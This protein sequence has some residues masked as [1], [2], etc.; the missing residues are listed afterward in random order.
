MA[1]NQSF[2]GWSM[3]APPFVMRKLGEIPATVAA[4]TASLSIPIVSGAGGMFLLIIWVLR[5]DGA[6][7]TILNLQFN[8]DTTGANYSNQRFGVA[9]SAAQAAGRFTVGRLWIYDYSN[10]MTNKF[11]NGECCRPDQAIDGGEGLWTPATG[12]HKDISLVTVVPAT[13]NFVA[14]CRLFA[15]GVL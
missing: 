5:T 12:F 13:G 14:G 9:C 7:Q 11:F 10:P 8:G 3:G 6:A 1:G 15:Y 2:V 4:T